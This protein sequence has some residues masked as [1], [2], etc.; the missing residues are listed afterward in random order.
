MMDKPM[1]VPSCGENA[2]PTVNGTPCS[3]RRPRV[4]FAP[5]VSCMLVPNFKVLNP[6]RKVGLW[7]QQQD[8]DEFLRVRVEVGRAYREAAKKLGRKVG[9]AYPKLPSMAHESRRGLGL[10]RKKQRAANRD[11]YIAGVLRE[12]LRQRAA[13]DDNAELSDSSHQM[14]RDRPRT[15]NFDAMSRV[16]RAISAQDAE[17]AH[18]VA[19]MYHETDMKEEAE[20]EAAG[21]LQGSLKKNPSVA[22]LAS[23][24]E[25]SIS[26]SGYRLTGSFLLNDTEEPVDDV[27][28]HVDEDGVK[29]KGSINLKGWGLS[30]DRLQE[31]GLSMTGHA[32]SKYQRLRRLPGCADDSGGSGASESEAS[33]GGDEDEKRP[34]TDTLGIS[35]PR[36]YRRWRM[37]ATVRTGL[38]GNSD[39]STYGTPREYRNWRAWGARA[40]PP[41]GG[42]SLPAQQCPSSGTDQS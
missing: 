1:H 22:T 29:H 7:W 38:P 15:I 40:K 13:H 41:K 23:E 27:E 14:S 35:S 42:V 19:Q 28:V 32:I 12:Q 33:D 39:A 3:S 2:E 10:G 24:S 11:K 20:A 31:V 16:A 37:G 36:T 25:E 4:Q 5:K 21:T 30:R 26:P 6:E 17:Y 9:G 8:F 18:N 34:R